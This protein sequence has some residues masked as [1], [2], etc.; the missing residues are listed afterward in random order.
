MREMNRVKMW[1]INKSSTDWMKSG[2]D[3]GSGIDNGLS[4]DMSS[5]Y[6][7]LSLLG[8]E[9]MIKDLFLCIHPESLSVVYFVFFG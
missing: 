2:K 4:I 7:F 5:T 9:G 1:R 3:E 8:F 6:I